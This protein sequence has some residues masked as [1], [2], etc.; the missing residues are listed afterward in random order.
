MSTHPISAWYTTQTMPGQSLACIWFQD[1]GYIDSPCWPSSPCA[2]VSIA[3]TIL[4]PA[5][6]GALLL[7]AARGCK[8]TGICCCKPCRGAHARIQDGRLM[9][10]VP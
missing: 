8:R 4:R 9:V 3:S 7:A 5:L 10:L 1:Q 6:L 2:S